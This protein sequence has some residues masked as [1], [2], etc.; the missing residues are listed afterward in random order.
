MNETF[1]DNNADNWMEFD[2]NAGEADE[3][4]QVGLDKMPCTIYFFLVT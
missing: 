2:P 3:M 1:G 4:Q